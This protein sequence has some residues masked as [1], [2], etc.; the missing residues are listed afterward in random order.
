[1]SDRQ[2]L[3]ALVLAFETGFANAQ[4]FHDDSLVPEFQGKEEIFNISAIMR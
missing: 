3:A 4:L 2:A 1:M